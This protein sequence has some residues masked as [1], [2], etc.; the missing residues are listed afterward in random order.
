M[1]RGRTRQS[2]I[3]D[4]AKKIDAIGLD[5]MMERV[6]Q[7]RKHD[8]PQAGGAYDTITGWRQRLKLGHDGQIRELIDVL[9]A[10]GLA[11]DEVEGQYR[12]R[13]GWVRCRLI[14]S[15]YMEREAAKK[16]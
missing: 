13:R 4:L 3:D 8:L 7:N 1:A 14:K 11:E 5:E 9:V 6:K 16:A 15:E 2:S 12:T 10:D